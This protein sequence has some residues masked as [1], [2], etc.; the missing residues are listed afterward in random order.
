MP[1]ATQSSCV[2]LNQNPAL[3]GGRSG[4]CQS[5]TRP[6]SPSRPSALS[7]GHGLGSHRCGHQ[8]VPCAAG[9]RGR[10]TFPSRAHPNAGAISGCSVLFCLR[11]KH[12]LFVW[13]VFPACLQG[14]WE[15]SQEKRKAASF[16]K[17]QTVRP[18]NPWNSSNGSLS[19]WE[20]G[21]VRRV[22]AEQPLH[23]GYSSFRKSGRARPGGLGCTSHCGHRS[24]PF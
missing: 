18:K 1:C 21:A 24:A 14:T 22:R 8:I 6:W 2:R 15:L 23:S 17:G 13:L 19:H 7:Q 3:N 9:E 16:P 4:G 20:P 12:I 5:W 11:Q 10:F